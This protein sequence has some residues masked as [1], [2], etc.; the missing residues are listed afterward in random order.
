MKLSIVTTLYRSRAHLAEFH[1]R[2]SR[3]G[4]DIAGDDFE[5]VMVNDGSP[6]D[7]LAIAIELSQ[8]DPRLVIVDLSR[9]F[10]H[11]RALMTGLR[12]ARGDFVFLIDSDLEEEPEHLAQFAAIMA[13]ERCDVVFGVQDRRKGGWWER[14]SGAAFYWLHGKLTGVPLPRNLLTMRLMTRRYVRALLRHRER[15]LVISS[16]WQMTGFVQRPVVVRKLSLSPTTYSQTH[17][18]TLLVTGVAAVSSRP[19]VGIFWLGSL[20]SLV[21]FGFVC[22]VVGRWLFF[23]QPPDGW[24]SLIASVWLLGGLVIWSLGLV[25]IYLAQVFLEVK[26]RPQTVVRRIIPAKP[27]AEPQFDGLLGSSRN[28]LLVDLVSKEIA[29]TTK[30]Q[31]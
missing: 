13:Q 20:V 15:V 5:I 2:A 31:E 26:Q 11:H 6:D 10:G 23:E 9:N 8:G 28:S 12:H 30:A 24:T 22:W 3:V 29:F 4:R 25:G 18:L 27:V 17:K 19:L 7:S 1:A 14:A 16:L 21:A